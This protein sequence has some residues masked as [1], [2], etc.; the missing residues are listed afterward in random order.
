MASIGGHHHL[1]VDARFRSQ[2]KAVYEG[3]LAGRLTSLRDNEAVGGAVL[4]A[5]T[6]VEVFTFD[7]GASIACFY[8]SADQALSPEQHLRAIWLEFEVDD[9]VRGTAALAA[10]GIR[11]FAYEDKTHPYF[12][13][14]GGQVFRLGA[15]E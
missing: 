9:V 12:Q 4:P 3:V 14:P 6:D 15:R 13:A 1:N 5:D 2:T 7:G 10:L 11:P 8:V